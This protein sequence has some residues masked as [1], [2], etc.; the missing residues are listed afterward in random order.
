LARKLLSLFQPREEYFIKGTI[1]DGMNILVNRFGPSGSMPALVA[2]APLTSNN[3][4]VQQSSTMPGEEVVAG[5][6]HIR[7][8][9]TCSELITIDQSAPAREGRQRIAG[10]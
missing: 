4:A 3:N 7:G 6:M 5:G 1:G 10:P 8:A 2:A 9:V